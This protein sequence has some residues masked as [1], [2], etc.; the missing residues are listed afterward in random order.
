[1]TTEGRGLVVVGR[2][3]D[4]PAVGWRLAKDPP[5]NLRD[6][7]NGDAEAAGDLAQLEAKPTGKTKEPPEGTS[8]QA[9]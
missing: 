1:M 6:L 9:A 2:R 5:G 8:P 7:T 4:E 3:T